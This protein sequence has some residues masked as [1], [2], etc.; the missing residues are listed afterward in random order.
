MVMLQT[1]YFLYGYMNLDNDDINLCESVL[2]GVL[3]G[4]EFIYKES[5]V[6][7]PLKAHDDEKKNLKRNQIQK[8]DK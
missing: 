7:R 3:R 1:G 2:G 5:G 4:V 6:N 8:S